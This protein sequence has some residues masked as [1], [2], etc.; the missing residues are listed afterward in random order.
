[1]RSKST[2]AAAL[3][4]AA[5]VIS[6]SAIV[7]GIL[8]ISGVLDTSLSTMSIKEPTHDMPVSAANKAVGKSA[9]INL[10]RKPK[11]ELSAAAA[12]LNWGSPKQDRKLFVLVSQQR[13]GS[14]WTMSNIMRFPS[15]W[16]KFME[17]LSAKSQVSIWGNSSVSGAVV[18]SSSS[19]NETKNMIVRLV[20]HSR[21]HSGDDEI[22]CSSCS[23][24]FLSSI[25]L[26]LRV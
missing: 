16:M 17:P 22:G 24:I 3:L 25:R 20:A 13:S 2:T 15:I 4:V 23:Q 11:Q 5:L 14:K 12:K 8:G 6:L 10:S 18:S 19:S 1:M 7:F 21:F 9:A 26:I